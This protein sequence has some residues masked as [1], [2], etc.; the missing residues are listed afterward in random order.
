MADSHWVHGH[1]GYRRRHG[2]TSSRTTSSPRPKIREDH[3]LDCIQH[4]RLLDRH[5]PALR[6][7]DSETKGSTWSG[8]I[9]GGHSVDGRHLLASEGQV[10][11]A[12]FS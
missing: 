3:L 9:A 2:D 11:D 12:R 1:P 8:A 10:K 4:D 7:L 6:S 5:H